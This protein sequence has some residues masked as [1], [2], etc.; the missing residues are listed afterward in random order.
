MHGH[1]AFFHGKVSRDLGDGAHIEI[2]TDKHI[3]CSLGQCPQK[4]CQCVRECY[5]LA[6]ICAAVRVGDALGQFIQSQR[7]LSASLLRMLRLIAVEG[8][9]TAD[10]ADVG[11]QR[12]GAVWR[13]GIPGFQIDI[14]DDFL[15][16]LVVGKDLVGNIVAIPSVLFVGFLDGGLG[17]LLVQIDNLPIFHCSILLSYGVKVLHPNKQEKCALHHSACQYFC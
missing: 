12:I 16:V 1:V 8:E 4:A 5:A 10:G 7:Y 2:P 14:V 15:G 6:D 13:Y 3:P 17:T 11:L 9:L